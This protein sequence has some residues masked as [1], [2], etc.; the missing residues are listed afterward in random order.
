MCVDDGTDIAGSVGGI[1]RADHC[2]GFAVLDAATAPASL[3]QRYVSIKSEGKRGLHC[4]DDDL[5]AEHVT[6]VGLLVNQKPL[7]DN[8]CRVKTALIRFEVGQGFAQAAARV[9]PHKGLASRRIGA[10]DGTDGLG[11][12]SVSPFLGDVD[13]AMR[14]L[15]GLLLRVFHMAI[16]VEC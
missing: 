15:C 16:T 7:G 12:R 4:G 8:I 5:C 6:L 10:R 14:F 11:A 13:R 3:R 1:P 2:A 9:C